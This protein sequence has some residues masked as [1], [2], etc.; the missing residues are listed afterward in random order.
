MM[1]ISRNYGESIS[2]GTCPCTVNRRN[3]CSA[4]RSEGKE[5]GL[6]FNGAKDN[7][8]RILCLLMSEI[9]TSSAFS[10]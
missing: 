6:W 7:Y 10:F 2:D 8:A 4:V 9:G 5:W 1:M 3:G